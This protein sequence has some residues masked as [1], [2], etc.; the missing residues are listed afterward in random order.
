MGAA[1][2]GSIT[3]GIDTERKGTN[4]TQNRDLNLLATL[5]LKGKKPMIDEVLEARYRRTR[6]Q[7]A[8]IAAEHWR[9]YQWPQDQSQEASPLDKPTPT[10]VGRRQLK[11]VDP[12]SD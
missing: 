12:H 10:N 5:E 9:N 8:E 11:L 2:G 4:K 1:I 3:P 6:R 7:I